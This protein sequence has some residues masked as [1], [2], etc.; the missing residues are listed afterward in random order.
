[1]QKTRDAQE[2]LE[3]L[4]SLNKIKKKRITRF[5]MITAL[6]ISERGLE[7]RGYNDSSV[8]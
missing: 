8:W 7:K 6:V 2:S 5:F 3:P 4:I 1:M